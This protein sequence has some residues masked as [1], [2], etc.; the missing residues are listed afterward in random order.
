MLKERRTRSLIFSIAGT[1]DFVEADAIQSRRGSAHSQVRA[2]G[3]EKN[4][5]VSRYRL[6]AAIVARAATPKSS[7]PGQA[8][9]LGWRPK[10][11]RTPANIA[12]QDLLPRA[13]PSFVPILF[14]L[15]KNAT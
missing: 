5:K 6:H 8:H 15:S 9:N 11:F 2:A 3:R 14:Q 12:D 13:V 1:A 10:G 4:R 7:G